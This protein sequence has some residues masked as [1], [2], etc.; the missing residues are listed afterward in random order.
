VPIKKISEG[1]DEEN[2]DAAGRR[3][4]GSGTQS[5]KAD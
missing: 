2:D 3:F 5:G 4:G 1:P